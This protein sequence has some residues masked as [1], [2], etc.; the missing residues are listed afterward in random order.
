MGKIFN[1]IVTAALTAA[2][3]NTFPLASYAEEPQ[4]EQFPARFDMR[5]LYPVTP[6][7]DQGAYGT[8][9]AHSAIASAESSIARAV[10]QVDLSEFH[11]A[12]YTYYGD[13]QIKHSADDTTSILKLGGTAATVTSLWAQWIGPAREEMLTYGDTAF[14]DDK[15]AVGELRGEHSYTLKNAYMFDYN[16][17]RTDE[18][19]VNSR[20][21][22]FVSRGLA[23]DVAY[24]SDSTK[25]YDHTLCSTNSRKKP[26][27]ANHSVAIIGWDDSYPAEN[28]KIPAE[29][30]GAW[31]VKNSWGEHYGDNGY[32]WISYEDRSLSDFAVYELESCDEYKYNFH[33]DSY[34]PI[35]SLSAY[36]DPEQ[37]GPSYMANVFTA[38]K[39]VRI[40]S[41]GT[42]ICA[43][44]TEYEITVYTGITDET[45]PTS[46]TPSAVTRGEGTLTGYVTLDLDEPV[47]AGQKGSEKFSAVV[48]LTNKTSPFVIPI[49][50]CLRVTDDSTGRMTDLG[51]Y[52]TTEGI[53][54]HTGKNE[55]F[56]SADGKT[57]EDTSSTVYDY[58]DD[59]EQELLAQLEYDLYDGL[60]P[61]ETEELQKAGKTLEKFRNMF[62]TGSVS[63]IIGNISL[64]AFA[65][66][67]NTPAFSHI[68]GAVPAG[69]SVSL[70]LKEGGEVYFS[71]SP[72]GNFEK[73]TAPIEIPELTTIYASAFPDGR[74]A[75]SR[76]YYPE[77]AALSALSYYIYSGGKRGKMQ[78]CTFDSAEP[79]IIIEADED[80]DSICFLPK[81]TASVGFGD[82]TYS[83]NSSVNA[84]IKA[85]RHDEVMKLSR[86]GVP[87]GNVLITVIKCA[88]GDADGNGAVD[89]RDASAVLAHYSALSVG[90]S[91][92][93]PPE[94]QKYA[95]F[96]GSGS[97]DSKD[98]SFILVR[99]AELSTS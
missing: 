63:M 70:S 35:Q 41:I 99:Y 8:C 36:D 60:E 75:V 84:E 13:D 5:E 14:F 31:L 30:A 98:A 37:L 82:K 12:Y 77:S 92:D 81:S 46:G 69:E 32:I 95:D 67:P 59:D 25:C 54:S 57:W 97:I 24:Y 34:V 47:F 51:S 44:D 71:T 21:K 58:T 22:S 68:A 48:K 73:Y 78:K 29:K 87:D 6:V 17:E 19:E 2:L 76:R 50:S 72:E 10:P 27:F 33:H 79:H 91:G 64:K 40:D 45:D 85:G 42:Y 94:M 43:P 74:N 7:K 61:E 23:V 1:R 65:N 89:A 39:P 88:I 3:L 56:F 93:I 96:D 53:T 49:E 28:F 90:E 26:R 15:E 66:D 86:K 80:A 52:T 18:A 4:P 16:K 55:S 62:D 11:T 20:I 83:P 38:D 9:W